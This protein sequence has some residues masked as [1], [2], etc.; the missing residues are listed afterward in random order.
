MRNSIIYTSWMFPAAFF[1]IRPAWCSYPAH[2]GII[3]LTRAGNM[4]HC[5]DVALCF[6]NTQYSLSYNWPSYQFYPFQVPIDCAGFYVYSYNNTRDTKKNVSTK[7]LTVTCSK[8]IFCN[9]HCT[10][11]HSAVV[12]TSNEWRKHVDKLVFCKLGHTINSFHETDPAETDPH[13][14]NMQ[15]HHSRT[16]YC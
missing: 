14:G 8:T 12:C 4:L 2:A 15:S 10:K 13:A 3:L 16:T 6:I 5:W 7:Q 1:R 11:G 9:I